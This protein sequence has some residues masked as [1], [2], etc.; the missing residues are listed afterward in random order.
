MATCIGKSALHVHTNR[1]KSEK[2]HTFFISSTVTPGSAPRH[3][4]GNH[5]RDGRKCA[6]LHWLRPAPSPAENRC[7]L[8][9]GIYSLSYPVTR[10]TKDI[11]GVP[12]K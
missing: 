3:N 8:A 9:P 1:A 7:A 4:M 6:D 12:V 2:V 10:A 5:C 11:S